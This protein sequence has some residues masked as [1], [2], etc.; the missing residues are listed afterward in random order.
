MYPDIQNKTRNFG[1]EK[2]SPIMRISTMRIRDLGYAPGQLQPGPKN[3]I[4]DVKGIYRI[5]SFT[6]IYFCWIICSD[7]STGVRVGQTTIH[8]GRD[9]HTG[10]TVILPR[11]PDE[12]RQK[13]CY[14]AIHKL[15]G[16]GEMTGAHQIEEFGSFNTVDSFSLSSDWHL[17][18]DFFLSQS[19]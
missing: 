3:S 15:N 18:S 11:G 5:I 13:P 12:I 6:C 14:A 16:M 19:H 2:Q 10:V 1:I 9:T 4:L 7:I 8:E 17:I